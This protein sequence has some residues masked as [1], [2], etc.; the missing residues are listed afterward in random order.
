MKR[1]SL[2]EQV[3]G[4]LGKLAGAEERILRKLLPPAGKS[5]P[6]DRYELFH[7]VLAPAIVDW[8]R[9]AL[10]ERKHA[11]EARER[12]RLEREKQEAEERAHEE[13]K[14]R[15]AFQRLAAGALALLLV[16]VVLAV[17]A[18]VAEQNAN[19]SLKSATIGRP[20]A[21]LTTAPAIGMPRSQRSR[22]A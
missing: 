13:A 20:W 22:G 10:E 21:W 18:F 19:S 17:V 4:V 16:A 3:A 7:D 5:Q 6:A 12:E 9:R 1:I 8:R 14:R 2:S 11:E 15:R